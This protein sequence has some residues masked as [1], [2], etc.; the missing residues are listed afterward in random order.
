M[1]SFV[2]VENLRPLKIVADTA[3]GMGGLIVPEVFK[4]LP[5]ELEILYPELDGTFPNHPAEPDP[6]REPCRPALADTAQPKRRRPRLRR[7]RGP[8]VPR[9]REGRTDVGIADDRDR[10]RRHARAVSRARRSSTTSSARTRCPRSSPS[11][12][13][14]PIRTRVGHSFIKAVMAETGAIFGGEHSGHYYFRDNFTARLR[15]HRRPRRA[16]GPLQG[17]RSALR[18]PGALRALLGLRRDQHRSARP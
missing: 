4:G 16:R 12:G 10:Q 18:A 13:G 17:R 1:R 15:D 3:N 2:Y 7:R 8:R 5:F 6:G 9:R 11:D 14:V